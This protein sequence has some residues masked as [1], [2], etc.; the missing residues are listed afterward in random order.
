M[1][2]YECHGNNVVPVIREENLS[3]AAQKSLARLREYQE[4]THN[5]R[6]ECEAERMYGA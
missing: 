3:E 5:Y 6:R 4:E 2:C 1:T